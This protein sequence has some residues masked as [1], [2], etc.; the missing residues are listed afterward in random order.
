YGDNFTVL[1]GAAGQL[2]A[3]LSEIEGLIDIETSLDDAQP[4]L[5]VRIDRDLASDLGVSLQQVG[6]TLRPMLGGEEVT[7]WTSPTGDSYGVVVRLPEWARD[8]VEALGSLPIIQSGAT[9]S[10]EMVRLEQ[11]AEI[12]QS[13][14]PGEITRQDLSRQVTVTANLSGVELGAVAP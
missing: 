13:Q 4:V 6:A 11:V 14:A 12:T 3:G 5:G 2:Q 10:T 1:E 7:E 8:E 9:G